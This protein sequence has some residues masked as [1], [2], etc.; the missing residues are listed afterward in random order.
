[1]LQRSIW[2]PKN[3]LDFCLGRWKILGVEFIAFDGGF[4][5]MHA[6]RIAVG[7]V[8]CIRLATLEGLGR[9]LGSHNAGHSEFTA[10]NGRMAGTTAS[11]CHYS[12]SHANGGDPFKQKNI[13]MA[14]K[15]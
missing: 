9:I 13:Y 1:M 5:Q 8:H 12:R 4:A 10:H 14:V 6:S 7:T 15:W 2:V 3:H 11:V